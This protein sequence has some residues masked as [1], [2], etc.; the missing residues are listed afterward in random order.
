MVLF[1]SIFVNAMFDGSSP[2]LVKAALSGFKYS[3]AIWFSGLKGDF[4]GCEQ[5][6]LDTEFLKATS[7]FLLNFALFFIPFLSIIFL[8][9]RLKHKY[10]PFKQERGRLLE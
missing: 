1:Q 10:F 7:S 5:F 8:L 6:L 4:L 3:L 2:T 9:Y